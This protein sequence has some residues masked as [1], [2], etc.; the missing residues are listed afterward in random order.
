MIENF[1]SIY[2]TL[3]IY[4]LNYATPFNITTVSKMP[5]GTMT[6]GITKSTTISTTEV[7]AE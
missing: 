1:L 3:E 5:F 7:V 2:F 4:S 6:L